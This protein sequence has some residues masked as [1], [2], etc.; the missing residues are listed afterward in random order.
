M[1][2]YKHVGGYGVGLF[3]LFDWLVGWFG[4]FVLVFTGS[5]LFFGL[6]FLFGL[7]CLSYSLT[8]PSLKIMK[9]YV[10]FQ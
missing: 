4:G 7:Y 2:T 6:F 9:C 5:V 3:S 10:K 1:D 8:R